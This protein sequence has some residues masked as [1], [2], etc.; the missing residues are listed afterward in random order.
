VFY[1]GIRMPLIV[2]LLL[3]FVRRVVDSSA[4]GGFL[5]A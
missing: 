2:I 1:L 4:A 3:E 5:S